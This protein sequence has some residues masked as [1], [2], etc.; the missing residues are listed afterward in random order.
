MKKK[1]KNG[2]LVLSLVLNVV[3]INSCNN[4][5]HLARSYV[6]NPYRIKQYKAIN[7]NVE[8]TV[9]TVIKAKPNRNKEVKIYK[10][11]EDEEYL[12][13]KISQCEAGNCSI[14]TRVKIMQCIWNRKQSDKFPDT[15]EEV[16]F[17]NS[18][19][20]Y[21]FTPV[22]PNGSWYYKEPTESDY[23][24]I[25]VFKNK[26]K[27]DSENILYFEDCENPDNWHSRNLEYINTFDGIR[28]Y[29]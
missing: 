28:F 15:I 24:A 9:E 10:L 23:E 3:T 4:Y 12:L 16:I 6:V 11:S 18:N 14:E 20:I 22:S 13:A 26:V 29:R 17:Q 5:K 27:D 19:G 1:I 7:V 21:Q 25:E 8:N 2:V